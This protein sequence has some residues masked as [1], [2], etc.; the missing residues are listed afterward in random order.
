MGQGV[1]ELGNLTS[2]SIRYPLLFGLGEI[3]TGMTILH[4]GFFLGISFFQQGI[5]VSLKKCHIFGDYHLI[6]G[7]ENLKSDL[8]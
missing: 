5:D 8:K 6:C 1:C 3:R 2:T 4:S 7:V